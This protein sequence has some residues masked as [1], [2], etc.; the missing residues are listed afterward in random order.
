MQVNGKVRNEFDCQK[1]CFDDKNCTVWSFSVLSLVCYVKYDD[2]CEG[3]VEAS[4]RI[5]GLSKVYCDMYPSKQ[6]H[7]IDGSGHSCSRI[8]G[9]NATDA[10]IASCLSRG[11]NYKTPTGFR[12]GLIDGVKHEYACHELCFD[13][14]WCQFWTWNKTE[15]AAGTGSRCTLREDVRIEANEEDI[16]SGPK[17][18]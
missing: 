3:R 7:N 14:P 8:S 1:K 2:L 13:Q 16:V 18:C 15:A 10:I 11:R 9:S 5:S 4:E 6:S 17:Y 12:E